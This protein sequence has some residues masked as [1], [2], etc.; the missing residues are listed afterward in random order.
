MMDTEFES[1]LKNALSKFTARLPSVDTPNGYIF[2]I[3]QG[4]CFC[5][6]LAKNH[7][8]SLDAWGKEYGFITSTI[9]VEEIDPNNRFIP[10]T[11]AVIAVDKNR[12]LIYMGP[13]SRGKGCFSTT[14]M[15]DEQL[16]QWISSQHYLEPENKFR[17]LHSV[18]ETEAEGCYCQV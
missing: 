2:H 8:Q 3:G 17:S 1:G 13:Y 18:I 6:S 12:N 16:T 10:S 15:V 7:Q 11:P 5:E 4:S 9:R 14:G